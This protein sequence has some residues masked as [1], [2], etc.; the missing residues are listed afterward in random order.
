M[1]QFSFVPKNLGF[2]TQIS[3]R[4]YKRRK[5]EHLRDERYVSKKAKPKTYT[6]YCIDMVRHVA[7]HYDIPM[8]QLTFGGYACWTK[9]H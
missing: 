6:Q 9:N 7:H 4:A 2:L 5:D 3:K 1:H 8:K